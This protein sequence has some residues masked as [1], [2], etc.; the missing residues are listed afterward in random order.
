MSERPR[1]QEVLEPET[2]ERLR[3]LDAQDIEPDALPARVERQ[4]PRAQVV[5]ELPPERQ[6]GERAQVETLAIVRHS[7]QID[8]LFAALAAA[9]GEFTEVERTLQATI[10]SR[11][12]EDSSFKY[13]YAP[14][15]EVLQAIRPA[16]SK[17]GIAI[18]QFPF[19][20]G[21]GVV[22]VRT[23]L[24]HKSGQWMYNDIRCRAEGDDPKAL[25]SAIT[26]LR[27]YAVQSIAGVA[28]ESDDDGGA[29]SEKRG[30]ER[31]R[32]AQRRSEQQQEERPRE[33]E[34]K[35]APPQRAP[36]RREEPKAEKTPTQATQAPSATVPPGGETRIGRLLG[37]EQKSGGV[38]VTLQGASGPAFR[39]GTK[40]PDVVAAFSV[41]AKHEPAPTL[42]VTLRP[43]SDPKYV[44]V[45]THVAPARAAAE[46]REPGQEG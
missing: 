42:A 30:A 13:E 45:I 4:A 21:G 19:A 5:R 31:P 46:T 2:A 1:Q 16:L 40:D 9:Q 36:E 37:V 24:G 17:S 8:Q 23:M 29:A 3:D 7:E 11:K 15:S 25:G 14:L 6:P 28:P 22:T 27:R 44:P 35:A 43:A 41:Y 32:P 18:M 26:Y 20:G 12:G 38:V 33:P 34:R 10:K 39:C